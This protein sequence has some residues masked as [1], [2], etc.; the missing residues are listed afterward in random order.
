MENQTVQRVD[1]EGRSRHPGG[2][3]T[4]NPG[5]GRVGVD[6]MVASALD[7]PIQFPEGNDVRA[8]IDIT[9]QLGDHDKPGRL[10]CPAEQLSLRSVI[11][12]TAQGNLVA[13]EPIQ[14]LD[15]QQGVLLGP[16]HDHPGDDVQD[17][18]PLAIEARHDVQG[19]SL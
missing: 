7:Q 12:A 4:E 9:A 6:D 1:D 19:S 2:Q 18:N 5:L 11:H 13:R 10:A 17:A 3:A 8:G 15:G 14:P 16:S